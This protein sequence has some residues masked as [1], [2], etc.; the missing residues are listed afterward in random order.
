M[1]AR[2]QVDISIII[3]LYNRAGCVGTALNSVLS[4]SI[5]NLQIICVDDGSTDSS[6]D[7]VRSI[8]AGDDRIELYR[9]E[10]SGPGVARNT[11]LEHATG[12]YVAFLDSDDSYLDNDALEKMVAFA[13][14]HQ[15]NVVG[16]RLYREEDGHVILHNPYLYRKIIEPSGNRFSFRDIQYPYEYTAFIFRRDYLIERNLVFP[17]YYLNEDVL[18]LAKVLH[19][20][21]EYWMLP[22][23]LYQVHIIPSKDKEVWNDKLIISAFSGIR[24]IMKLSVENDYCR[25][26]DEMVNSLFS[27]IYILRSY[28]SGRIALILKEIL[29]IDRTYY[30]NP[31]R[32]GEVIRFTADEQF[33]INEE[34]LGY[35]AGINANHLV[36]GDELYN[37]IEEYLHKKD[38]HRVLIYGL[39]KYGRALLDMLDNTDIEVTGGIDKKVS[40]FSGIPVFRPGDVL[41]DADA[42]II[43]TRYAAGVRE[44]LS[45]LTN[46]E[47][48]N[49]FV[50]IDE[51]M[52]I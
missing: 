23:R 19:S 2:S 49:M 27:N 5:G 40:E 24:D 11:G 31:G 26:Y 14:D 50:M 9:I 28:R 15:A 45:S 29:D 8:M 13:D 30:E 32:I 6:A 37:G 17:Q 4:Q 34:P 18:F 21:G 7:V 52:R 12:R 22:V 44:L 38:I 41:P 35:K 33:E 20:V 16:S 43:A 51:V 3:P 42:V 48:I 10:N 47:I 46:A 25:L 39:G 36:V 1:K